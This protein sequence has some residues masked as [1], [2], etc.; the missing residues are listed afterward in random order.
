MLDDSEAVNNVKKSL[1][2]RGG[3][4]ILTTEFAL[5]VQSRKELFRK[6]NPRLRI[7][8]AVDPSLP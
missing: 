1:G 6:C 5:Q 2:E 7:V 4:D 3:K 8:H